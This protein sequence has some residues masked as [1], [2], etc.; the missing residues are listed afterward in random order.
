M[1]ISDCPHTCVSSPPI[2]STL[3]GS[4]AK[5][6]RLG[7]ERRHGFCDEGDTSPDLSMPEPASDPFAEASRRPGHHRRADPPACGVA[8]WLRRANSQVGTTRR[9]SRR[10]V[11]G[12]SLLGD[13]SPLVER[14]SEPTRISHPSM[15]PERLATLRPRPA[16][17]AGTPPA[18][19]SSRKS[20]R[21]MATRLIEPSV[22]TSTTCHPAGPLRTT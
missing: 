12:V 10:V 22:S 3:L 20:E 15:P 9:R 18:I 17:S 21:C 8:M 1:T 6:S 13:A 5:L 7:V 11:C 4:L 14:Q 19:N 16:V 2:F